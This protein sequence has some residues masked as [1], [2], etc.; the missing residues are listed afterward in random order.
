LWLLYDFLFILIFA[1]SLTDADMD[2]FLWLMDRDFPEAYDY[3]P[4]SNP[5]PQHWFAH[6]KAVTSYIFHSENLAMNNE[7]IKLL[8]KM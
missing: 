8:K 4:D 2:P 7:H 3:D 5:C 1:W 6:L